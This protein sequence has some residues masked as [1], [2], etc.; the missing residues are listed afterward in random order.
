MIL[1][2][3]GDL[4]GP[5]MDHQCTLAAAIRYRGIAPASYGQRGLK[6]GRTPWGRSV[7]PV[8]YD[9]TSSRNH[10]YGLRSSASRSPPKDACKKASAKSSTRSSTLSPGDARLCKF[11]T[12]DTISHA[13]GNRMRS[14]LWA[15]SLAP[16]TLQPKINLCLR[17]L[18]LIVVINASLDVTGAPP[19][20]LLTS[21]SDRTFCTKCAS[22][23]FCKTSCPCGES[24]RDT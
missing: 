4:A 15:A 14:N 12:P 13:L 9:P 20:R 2:G 11:I 6:D 16:L 17:A 1:M 8:L 3:R 10:Q 7:T 18:S 23:S 19:S 5:R 22:T 24:S 21:S